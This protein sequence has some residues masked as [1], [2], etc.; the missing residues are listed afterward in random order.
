MFAGVSQNGIR[1]PLC[2]TRKGKLTKNQRL[3]G[4]LLESD[5]TGLLCMGLAA[6]LKVVAFGGFA[7]LLLRGE[8]SSI[9]RLIEARSI[10][11]F[12]RTNRRTK[13]NW[14]WVKA[15]GTLLG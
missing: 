14:L 8:F 3:R 10:Y 11:T 4:P 2:L 6:Y 12:I 7:K 13:P 15:N 1:T 9:P 5:N